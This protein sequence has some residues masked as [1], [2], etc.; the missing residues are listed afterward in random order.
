MKAYDWRGSTD[1]TSG[2]SYNATTVKM[3]MIDAPGADS[4]MRK[5]I[6]DATQPGLKASVD[7]GQGPE[8]VFNMSS[9]VNLTD[10][11][12]DEIV[13]VPFPF[14]VCLL[15]ICFVTLFVFWVV[16]VATKMVYTEKPF[17][18]PRVIFYA[19][20]FQIKITGGKLKLIEDR[21]PV[22]ITSPG[23]P[24]IKVAIPHEIHIR[25]DEYGV[26][27]VGENR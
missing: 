23:A 22:N 21:P 6:I 14:E 1:K 15:F 20:P 25:R 3:N 26:I 8:L 9:V 16:V 11:V 27:Y 5:L 18:G 19:F 7:L 12:E 2:G 4:P 13:P 17:V 10:L 24:P